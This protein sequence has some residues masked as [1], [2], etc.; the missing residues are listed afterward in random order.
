MELIYKQGDLVRVR[1]AKYTKF[2]GLLMGSVLFTGRTVDELNKKAGAFE[3]DY[4]LTYK[5]VL[6]GIRKVAYY[7]IPLIAWDYMDDFP[8][9][10]FPKEHIAVHIFDKGYLSEQYKTSSRII[11]LT[12]NLVELLPYQRDDKLTEISTGETFRV[13]KILNRFEASKFRFKPITNEVRV[14]LQSADTFKSSRLKEVSY[15]ELMENFTF[16]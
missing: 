2:G 6:R 13:N 5:N 11:I 16:E 14:A 9:E 10:L 4:R 15:L 7:D 8:L 1:D 3:K 12:M